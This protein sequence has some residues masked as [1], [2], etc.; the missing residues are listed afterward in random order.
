MAGIVTMEDIVET[1][2]GA[3]IVDETDLA[4]DLQAMAKKQWK[5]RYKKVSDQAKDTT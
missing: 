5:H 3:E 1:L 4:I 2:L